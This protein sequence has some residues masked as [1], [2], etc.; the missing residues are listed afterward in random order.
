MACCRVAILALVKRLGESLLSITNVFEASNDR[1]IYDSDSAEVLKS[2][3][4]FRLL[5]NQRLRLL[6][7][8][9][10]ALNLRR[11][12]HFLSLDPLFF[13]LQR[14]LVMLGLEII[15][16]RDFVT[17]SLLHVSDLRLDLIDH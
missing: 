11:H 2:L 15:E 5:A 6:H 17:D 10:Q 14:R 13:L 3:N 9:L 12:C 1:Y 7:L 16:Q 8:V 4:F